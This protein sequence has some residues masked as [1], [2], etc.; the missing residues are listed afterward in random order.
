MPIADVI[1]VLFINGVGSH[2]IGLLAVVSNA[3]VFD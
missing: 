1:V 2:L 3:G